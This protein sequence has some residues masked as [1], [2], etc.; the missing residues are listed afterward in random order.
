MTKEQFE[1]EIHRYLSFLKGETGPYGDGW[2]FRSDLFCVSTAGLWAWEAESPQ[3]CGHGKTL[4]LALA[5]M[6][7]AEV[8]KP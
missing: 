3:A 8:S 7:G 2:L 6:M 5:S 1:A 4:P